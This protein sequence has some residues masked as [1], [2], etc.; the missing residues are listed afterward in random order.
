MRHCDG[1]GINRS[2]FQDHSFTSDRALDLPAGSRRRILRVDDG[3]EKDGGGDSV[4]RRIDDLSGPRI[5]DAS[6]PSRELALQWAEEMQK[7]LEGG[8]Q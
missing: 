5:L 7:H 3:L 4:A 1:I 2:V 8:G 6:R